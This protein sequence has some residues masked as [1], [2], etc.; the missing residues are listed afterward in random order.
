MS[1]HLAFHRTQGLQ[2]AGAVQL[3]AGLAHLS[4]R[5]AQVEKAD[6]RGRNGHR[7][8]EPSE[9]LPELQA[10]EDLSDHRCWIRIRRLRSPPVNSL[11]E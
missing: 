7:E 9:F 5:Q 2:I 10:V 6:Q 3:L 11:L 4:V 8:D 1:E